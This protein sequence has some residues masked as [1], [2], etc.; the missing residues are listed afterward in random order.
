MTLQSHSSGR[1]EVGASRQE[2]PGAGQGRGHAWE[3]GAGLENW[4]RWVENG[5]PWGD[6]SRERSGM[7]RLGGEGQWGGGSRE[8]SHEVDAGAAEIGGWGV[9]AGIEVSAGST[10]EREEIPKNVCGLESEGRAEPGGCGR[11]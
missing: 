9:V 11:P 4:A 3:A 7:V 1:E 2:G 10:G 5:L 8:T 6:W